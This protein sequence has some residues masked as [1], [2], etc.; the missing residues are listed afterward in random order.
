MKGGASAQSSLAHSCSSGKRAFLGRLATRR[1][2]LP[3]RPFHF[4]S[5]APFH[6]RPS[7]SPSFSLGGVAEAQLSSPPFRH[8]SATRLRILIRLFFFYF[9][10][11]PSALPFCTAGLAR[12]PTAPFLMPVAT[13][14]SAPPRPATFA[15]MEDRK[16][17]ASSAV[18]EVAPPSKRQAVNGSSKS[19]DD[20][21]DMR[22][23][24]WIEV[25][26]CVSHDNPCLVVILHSRPRVSRVPWPRPRRRHLRAHQ[27]GTKTP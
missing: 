9:F 24:A 10:F 26:E 3:L 14:P 15:K 17:P 27:T 12:L 6:H 1:P 5:H 8:L 16:R 18:D 19:K 23:E 4:P 25:S 20:S 13:T 7:L 22:E 11:F 21:G 2:V